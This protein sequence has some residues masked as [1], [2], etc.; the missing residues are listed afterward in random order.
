MAVKYTNFRGDE[1]F[2]HMRKTSKGNPSY[3]FKKNDDNTSVEEIPEGYEVYEHPNGRVFLTKTAK[4][5]ITKE[6]ISIIENALDKLSPIRDY[7]LDVKQKSIYIFTYENPVSFNEIPAVVEALSDPKY[8]TYEAQLCFTLTDKKSR[9]F[10]VERR[11]YRG[12]K[13]DQWLFLDASSNLKE[14]AENYVQHLGKEEFFEL[15]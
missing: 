13:D 1:Y 6:E 7:K 2:L 9:K 11:T 12:E 14:L 3:Y 5:G 8:K 15:V 10:Q 4:K